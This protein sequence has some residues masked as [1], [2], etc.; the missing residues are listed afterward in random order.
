MGSCAAEGLGVLR[1]LVFLS[2]V[3]GGCFW[4]WGLGV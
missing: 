2:G 1:L 3:A 4:R